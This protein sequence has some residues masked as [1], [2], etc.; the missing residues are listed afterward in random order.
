MRYSLIHPSDEYDFSKLEYGKGY[1][2]NGY[3]IQDE[4]GEIVAHAWFKILTE[5]QLFMEKIEV[6]KKREGHGTAIVHFLFDEFNLDGISGIVMQEMGGRP[7][8]F[9]QNLGAEISDEYYFWLEREN[10]NQVKELA[11]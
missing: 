2:G 7:Y 4:T 8:R 11:I 9:W 6:F 1:D 3:A 5:N 10:L